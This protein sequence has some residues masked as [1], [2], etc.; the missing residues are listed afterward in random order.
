M[1]DQANALPARG[2]HEVFGASGECYRIGGDE[3]CVILTEPC[4]IPQRLQHFDELVRSR[5]SHEFT[6][7]V[8]CGWETR[9]FEAG[10][11]IAIKDILELK[12]AADR[13]LYLSKERHRSPV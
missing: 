5:N 1:A 6:M 3:F 12:D 10:K 2:S 13:N 11:T 8:S 9:T 4:D 7:T